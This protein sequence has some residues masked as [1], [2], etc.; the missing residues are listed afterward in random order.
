M[1]GATLGALGDVSKEFEITEKETEVVH[2]RTFFY[3]QFL[4]GKANPPE[5]KESGETTEVEEKPT[6]T[7]TS[8]VEE[9]TTTASGS[10]QAVLLQPQFDPEED[11]YANL[12]GEEHEEL[13]LGR[14]DDEEIEEEKDNG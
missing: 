13:P 11:F 14:F 6:A 2:Q 8:I 1:C 3:N 12:R 10:N 7:T 9:K 4:E 5:K